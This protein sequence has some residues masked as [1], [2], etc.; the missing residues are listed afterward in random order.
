LRI[1][2]TDRPTRRR[3]FVIAGRYRLALRLIG[4]RDCAG[5]DVGLAH[6]PGVPTD[7]DSNRTPRA[8]RRESPR[9]LHHVPRAKTCPTNPGGNSEVGLVTPARSLTASRSPAP[10]NGQLPLERL[11][12]VPLSQGFSATS[13]ASAASHVVTPVDSSVLSL[14][15]P[16]TMAERSMDPFTE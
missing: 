4:R 5:A 13:S 12:K 10:P 16:A 9:W 11:K 14:G 3:R 15:L 6:A 2:A 7:R 1:I 8:T